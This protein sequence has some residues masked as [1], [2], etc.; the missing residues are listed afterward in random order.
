MPEI[1]EINNIEKE[2]KKKEKDGNESFH[3][4]ALCVAVRQPKREEDFE[5]RVENESTKTGRDLLDVNEVG[6]VG[7]QR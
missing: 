1:E 6:C 5:C 7:G 2:K 3:T 4:S